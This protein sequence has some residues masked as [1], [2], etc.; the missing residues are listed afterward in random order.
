MTARPAFRA[1]E[2]ERGQHSRRWPTLRRGRLSVRRSTPPHWPIRYR[3]WRRDGELIALS[4]EGGGGGVRLE[5]VGGR[6]CVKVSLLPRPPASLCLSSPHLTDGRWHTVV[7]SRQGPAITLAADD[8]EGPLYNTS[9]SL[10]P[11]PPDDPRYSPGQA[12]EGLTV[13]GTPEYLAL[14][15]LSVRGDYFDGCLDDLRISGHKLP[16]PPAANASS[17]GEVRGYQGV[18]R[19]CA[20]PPVCANVTC[21]PPFTCVDTWRNYHCGCGTGQVLA[22]GGG[23]CQPLDQ[24]VYG[25]CLNGGTCYSPH[26]G[27]FVCTCEAGF[28]GRH[29]HLPYPDD[30]SLKLSLGALL[31][32][33]V[34]CTFLMLLVGAFLLHQ[35]HRR[36]AVRRG[37]TSVAKEDAHTLREATHAHAPTTPA[38]T[39]NLL[40]MQLLKPPKSNGQ[41]AWSRNPNIADVDVLQVDAASVTSSGAEE[42]P[43]TTT[44]PLS[45]SSGAGKKGGGEEEEEEEEE[46]VANIP[47]KAMI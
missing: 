15:V 6:L 32:L 45:S 30:P 41:P 47:L 9:L 4:S 26:S 14:S 36:A 37:S 2:A 18:E 40:E 31:A 22:R 3:T 8:A 42:H 24:C 19:G 5:L 1:G 35:H 44:C 43:R 29:C 12:D 39:P 33:I 27:G 28:S 20:A 46:G 17:W 34:W 16:L 38:H 7:F 21:P 25:P 11:P 10:L 13:G 23:S